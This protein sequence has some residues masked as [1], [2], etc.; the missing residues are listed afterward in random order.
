M[1]RYIS[2]MLTQDQ[3]RARTKTVTRRLGWKA[4]KPG[5]VLMGAEKCQGLGKGGKI[6]PLGLIRVTDVRQEPLRRMTE[7]LDYGL[8]EAR[9]EGFP[10]LPDD[11]P[12]EVPKYFVDF[13]CRSHK[14]CTPDS[15]VTRIEFEY[16]QE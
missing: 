9:A 10:G 1:P 11:E 3:I 8:A 12:K 14:G 6:K 4:L 7:D 15:D 2:F 5:T 13:F 16:L